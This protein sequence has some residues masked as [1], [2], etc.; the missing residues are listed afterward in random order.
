[1]V[2]RWDRGEKGLISETGIYIVIIIIYDEN[3]LIIA[4]L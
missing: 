4:N 3:T 2:P 1:M